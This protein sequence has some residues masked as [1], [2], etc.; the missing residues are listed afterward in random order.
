MKLLK[1]IYR[2]IAKNENYKRRIKEFFM[3]FGFRKI[4][5]RY[6]YSQNGEELLLQSFGRYEKDYKGFYVDI[7]AYHPIIY[8][9]TQY[10]YEQGWKGINIDARPGS[11]KIFN[12]IRKRDINLEIGISDKR[13][14]LEYYS[15][16]KSDDM[17]GFDS[18]LSKERM[19]RGDEIQEIVK[20]DVFTINEILKK[21]LPENQEIDFI[22]IDIEG[23]ELQIIKTLDFE[24]Y[25]PRFFLIEDYFVEE[26]FMEYKNTDLYLFLRKM[27]YIVIGK[28]IWTILFR[29][30]E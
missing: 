2:K 3:F 29:K 6:Y 13:G 30:I 25:S 16:K 15:F 8:S 23:L 5:Q 17:N 28:T 21:Y 4:F 7:G 14:E 19:S 10:F 22:T 18:V 20:M 9:N 1:Y 27:G 11:M 24:K 12:R 26:D